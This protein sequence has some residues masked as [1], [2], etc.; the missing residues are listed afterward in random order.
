MT[1][2]DERG[3]NARSPLPVA[4]PESAPPQSTW[5]RLV[6][7]LVAVVFLTKLAG[8]WGLLIVVGIVVMIFL[9]ELGHFIMAKRAGMKVTEFFIGFGPRIWSF[10]R[11]ETEYGLKVIPAGAYV[12]I[13][14]MSTAEQVDPEDESRTYRVKP[15]WQRFGV[16]VAG[17]TMHFIQAL[18]LIFVLLVGFGQPGGAVLLPQA[19]SDAYQV[20]DVYLHCPGAQAGLRPDDVFVSVDGQPVHDISDIGSSLSDKYGKTV[21]ITVSRDGQLE[22]FHPTLLTRTSGGV[23][24]GLLGVTY[25]SVPL[26]T[27]RVGV[28]KAIPQSF[29]ELGYGITTSVS[30]IVK[31]FRPSSLKSYGSQ[32]LDARNDRSIADNDASQAPPV[33]RV[34]PPGDEQKAPNDTDVT[35]KKCLASM[36]GPAAFSSKSMPS[37]DQANRFV[38]LVGIYQMGTSFGHS[39]G[40]AAVLALFALLNIFIG[41]FNLTPV[42]PFDGGHVVIAVYEKIR[43]RM[44]GNTGRYYADVTKMMPVVYVVIV[45]LGLIFVSSLYLDIANPV[46]V[47]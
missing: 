35:T 2:I 3:D 30:A 43:E 47:K 28:L 11:G 40:L 6:V 25:G 42:L 45:V 21:A 14:G 46:T 13:V 37:G 10:R 31:I 38:S 27:E 41:V 34:V 18:I 20:G 44:R 24:S 1:E 22:T 33:T 36:G 23:K 5:V 9:H 19:S 8:L 29:R 17:S 7:M 15:F 4:S 26:K 12:R 16:A 32:V 39:N